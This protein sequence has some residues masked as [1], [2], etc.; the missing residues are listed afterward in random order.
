[1]KALSLAI[2]LVLLIP[3][4]INAQS[5]KTNYAGTWAFNAEK[6][7]VGGGGQG[8][9]RGFGAGDMTVTQ[10]GNVLTV[11]STRPGRDGGAPVTT[12]TKYTLDGKE[13][14]NTSQRGESKSNATWSADGKSLTIKTAQTFNDMTMNSTQVWTLEGANLKITRTMTTQNGDMT[15]TMVYDKK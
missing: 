1:M 7:N 15:S 8:G 5:G 3:G 13:S 4:T 10:D 2:M 6:S 9:G 12:T 14:V 11:A